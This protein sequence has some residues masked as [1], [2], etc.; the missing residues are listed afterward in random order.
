MDILVL[1]T[2][3]SLDVVKVL[4][5]AQK[6]LDREMNTVV[7]RRKKF[8]EAKESGERF[9]QRLMSE[10]NLFVIGDATGL[11]KPG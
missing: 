4:A 10:P 8:L 5:H 7:I 1:G 3:S 11:G 2:V 9:V 6:R